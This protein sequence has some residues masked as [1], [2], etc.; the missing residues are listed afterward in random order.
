MIVK[1]N[2]RGNILMF[3]H[4][5]QA[6]VDSYKRQGTIPNMAQ[7]RAKF[8][9][10]HGVKVGTNGSNWQALEFAT[11]QDYLMATLKWR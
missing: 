3:K 10:T 2:T 4:M 6:I 5:N 1:I 11:E 7:H 9:E 8:E